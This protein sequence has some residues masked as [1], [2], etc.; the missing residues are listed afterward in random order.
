MGWAGAL[1]QAGCARHVTCSILGAYFNQQLELGQAMNAHSI[2]ID[3]FHQE[4]IKLYNSTF[5]V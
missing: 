3:L 1:Y 2:D 4:L 5:K